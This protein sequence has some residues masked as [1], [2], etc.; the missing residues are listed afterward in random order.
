LLKKAHASFNRSAC[1]LEPKYLT[2]AAGEVKLMME[3]E[4]AI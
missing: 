1:E 2:A 3:K 4:R